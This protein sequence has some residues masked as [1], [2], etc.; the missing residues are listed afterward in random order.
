[1]KKY[2]FLFVLVLI[3]S[4]GVGVNAES[5][6]AEISGDKVLLRNTGEDGIVE[7]KSVEIYDLEDYRYFAVRAMAETIGADISWDEQTKTVLLTQND[8]VISLKNNSSDIFINGSKYNF[9]Y[10]VIIIDGKSYAPLELYK[11]FT[12]EL[13]L[14][15]SVASVEDDTYSSSSSGLF[16]ENGL[17]SNKIRIKGASVGLIHNFMLSGPDRL[18]LDINGLSLYG[19][20]AEGQTFDRI[21]HFKGVDGI[22]RIVFDLK[23]PYQYSINHEG[24]DLVIIISE[25][26]NFTQE[27][28]F[29]E[30]RNNSIIINTGDYAG[31]RITRESDPFILKAILP[32]TLV[33][34]PFVIDVGGDLVTNVSVETDGENTVFS[35]QLT[36]QC[37]FELEKLSDAFIIG[38]YEPV[39]LGA[40]Y[41]NTDGNIYIEL[42]ENLSIGSIHSIKNS[43]SECIITV[44]DPGQLL[45][46]GQVYIN[47]D[48]I[49][50]LFVSRS[51]ASASIRITAKSEIFVKSEAVNGLTRL[52]V[53][54]KDYSGL[55][56]V[57]AAGHG[58]RDPGAVVNGIYES[59]LNLTI[60]NKIKELLENAGV[61]VHMIR[62]GDTFVSLE[63]RAKIANRLRAD[64]FVSI[65]CNTLDDPNFDGLM[66]LVHSGYINY[67]NI[68]GKTAGTIIHKELIDATGATDRGVRNRDKIIVLKE[69]AMP[70]VEIECG[71]LTNEVEFGKLLDDSYQWSI[72]RGT[73]EGILN[74]LDLMD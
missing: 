22:T 68:N 12:G 31:Y 64:L 27:Q 34:S 60:T 69:T 17:N 9:G 28:D 42:D 52:L 36:D 5:F 45:S 53:L 50:S 11:A 21:R 33:D 61:N 43:G 3:L 16:I 47:D 41:H 19:E 1:M 35:I 10:P 20:F 7:I 70:A 59:S 56:V 62:T 66:T 38:I 6:F 4:I 32:G 58:G 73:A 55:L 25:N 8:L 15:E 40:E 24:N 74:V 39:V 2:I 29:V 63:D 18:V 57:L 54:E 65:H 49:K 26:G 30:F 14:T 23:A 13:R 72:A 46:S 37:A 44:N 48:N 67:E 51:G 71:F